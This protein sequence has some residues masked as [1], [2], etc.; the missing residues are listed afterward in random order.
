MNITVMF[1]FVACWGGYT[2]CSG[3]TKWREHLLIEIEILIVCVWNYLHG[4]DHLLQVIERKRF[5]VWL[6]NNW[7]IQHTGTVSIDV[8]LGNK[9]GFGCVEFVTLPACIC[10]CVAAKSLLY[11]ARIPSGMITVNAVPT[12]KPAPRT[13]VNFNFC[14]D[15]RI[16]SGILPARYDPTSITTT[17]NN[18]TSVSS[19]MF[20]AVLL[21]RLR[22]SAESWTSGTML[23]VSLS[24]ASLHSPKLRNQQHFL[25]Y[26]DLTFAKCM[27]SQSIIVSFIWTVRLIY[28]VEKIF[29]RIID[30]TLANTHTNTLPLFHWKHWR[31]DRIQYAYLA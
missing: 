5:V 29:V 7:I 27:K 28:S 13:V 31:F 14:S 6:Q 19:T 16:T 20:A 9:C 23:Y 21:L 18:S 11:N 15:N 25:V 8:R 2:L 12:N 24:Q 17:S 22:W 10:V 1:V 4:Y 30:G 3:V 26:I